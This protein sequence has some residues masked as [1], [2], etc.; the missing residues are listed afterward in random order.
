MYTNCHTHIFNIRCAPDGFAGIRVAKK[1]SRAPWIPKKLAQGLRFVIPGNKDGLEKLAN[2]LDIG[3]LKTQAQVFNEMRSNYRKELRYVVLTLDMHYMGAG[4][5]EIDFESQIRQ[6]RE[7][8]LQHQDLLLPFIGVDPRRYSGIQLREYVR[9]AIEQHGFSGIKLY[10]PLGFYPFDPGL[11]ELYDYAQD[12]Q[13]PIMTHCSQG[14]IFFQ[15]ENIMYDQIYPSDLDQ[16]RARHVRIEDNHIIQGKEL[17]FSSDAKKLKRFLGK[18]RG[19]RK[20][21]SK[22]RLYFS[23]PQNYL[24]ILEKYP[25]LKICMAHFGGDGQIEEYLKNPNDLSNW[26][27]IVRELME[28]YENV[29]TDVSYALWNKKAWKPLMQAISEEGIG[30]KV[31]FGTDFYMTLQE[32]DEISLVNDFREVLN[33]SDFEKIARTNPKQFLKMRFHENR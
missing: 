2:F 13:I 6:V 18:T 31:L 5:S 23:N 32:K 16:K 12:L 1:F 17:D 27:R 22:F 21:N 33:H 3:I 14:G 15:N 30:D 11:R 19:K 9:R 7:L 26:H 29:Y 10:T 8:K 4:G 20:R 28:K 24:N 25:K